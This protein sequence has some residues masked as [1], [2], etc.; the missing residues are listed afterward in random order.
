[1]K[2]LASVSMTLSDFI[3]AVFLHDLRRMIYDADLH[4][5]GF[6]TIAV[7]IE[8]IGACFDQYPFNKEGLSLRRFNSGIRRLARVDSRYQQHNQP[9]SPYCLYRF[10]RCGMAH[11]MRPHGPVLFSSRSHWSEDSSMH[12]LTEVN[13]KLLL[14]C[15]DF[16]DDFAKSCEELIQELPGMTAPKLTDPYLFVGPVL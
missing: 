14:I 12:L 6:G 11:V 8:F 7:G 2:D 15:E 1:M 4:Y 5:L 10:L 16:Y 9:S 3:R 13:N